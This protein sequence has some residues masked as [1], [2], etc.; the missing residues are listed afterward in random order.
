MPVADVFQ[1][2]A[3]RL[4]IAVNVRPGRFAYHQRGEQVFQRITPFR[5]GANLYPG[6]HFQNMIRG[7]E[8]FRM[9]VR[10][11]F[12]A[13]VAVTHHQ[14]GKGVGLQLGQHVKALGT[15]QVVEAVPVLQHLHL[16]LKDEVECGSEHA[17]ELIFPL[18]QAAN[19]EVD[20][21]QARFFVS[22]CARAVEE[23]KRI[24]APWIV[25]IT[26]QQEI[27]RCAFTFDGL[28]I[29][30][31][32]MLSVGGHKVEDRGGIF[33]VNSKVSPALVG[34]QLAV[35]RQ[36]EELRT[37][38]IEGGHKGVAAAGDVKC[39]EIQRQTDQVI[40]Q[41]TGQE[42]IDFVAHLTG[43]PAHNRA[44]SGM[45]FHRA[46]VIEGQ[47]V[48]EG[49]NK[50]QVVTCHI[51]ADTIDALGEHR[52][53]EAVDHVGELGEDRRVDVGGVRED[54]GV[55]RRLDG[56]GKLFKYQVLVFHLGREATGLEQVFA[57][58]HQGAGIRRDLGDLVV[59]HQP[60]VDH[61]DIA[62][63]QNGGF[64]LLHQTVMFVVEHRVH[65]G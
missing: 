32:L 22:P 5:I 56:T 27:Y 11:A 33:Q 31:Q 39:A 14:G 30:D 26:K 61:A 28:C 44:D 51:H 10:G 64:V 42:L 50:P 47:W 45:T 52:V 62:G 20:H 65:R 15:A 36:F 8:Q 49:L 57:V 41:G 13:E 58:P 46:V 9:H 60:L 23:V 16:R 29:Q 53:A 3:I 25:G 48:K 18:C 7:H 55:D 19:P 24:G 1:V 43:H 38:L 12:I 63:A 21:V 35:A 17:A 54:K 59:R 2:S 37:G 40:A 4:A 6:V 34:F